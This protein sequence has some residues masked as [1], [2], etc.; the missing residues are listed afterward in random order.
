MALFHLVAVFQCHSLCAPKINVHL[1]LSHTQMIVRPSTLIRIRDSHVWTHRTSCAQ[2]DHRWI[3]HGVCRQH[4]QPHCHIGRGEWWIF[5][6]RC[7]Y[8]LPC[9]SYPLPC[10]S[11]QG[12]LNISV[13][14]TE[15]NDI[16]KIYFVFRWLGLRVTTVWG[17]WSTAM[18]CG[19]KFGDDSHG[20][21]PLW[22]NSMKDMMLRV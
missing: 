20:M 1:Y 10:P 8:C 19:G 16:F 5:L 18:D 12:G 22:M 9:W 6:P 17:V 11:T 2:H 15:I 7:W 13:F 14:L 21:K 4:C 3:R